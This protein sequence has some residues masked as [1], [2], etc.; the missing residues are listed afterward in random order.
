MGDG[1]RRRSGKRGVGTERHLFDVESGAN[2]NEDMRGAGEG[3]TDVEGIRKRHE[4]GLVLC[5]VV[6]SQS[7]GG[8]FHSKSDQARRGSFGMGRT[9][10]S[11]ERVRYSTFEG[12]RLAALD[13][14]EA[15]PELGLRGLQLGEGRGEVLELLVELVLHLGELLHAQGVEVHYWRG[16][17]IAVSLAQSDLLDRCP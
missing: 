12:G 14:A 15:V 16:S 5:R 9:R 3:S 11:S 6:Y 4:H 10:Y 7:H 8:V 2:I 13:T 17:K 1:E